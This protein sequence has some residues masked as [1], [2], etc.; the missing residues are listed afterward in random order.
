MPDDGR[1][2]RAMRC[3]RRMLE[4]VQCP[5][6]TPRCLSQLVYAVLDEIHRGEERRAER[7]RPLLCL[8]CFQPVEMRPEDA[9]REAACPGCGQRLPGPMELN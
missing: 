2:E 9:G 4:L 3:V 5:A 1:Y 7:P 8:G 6:V